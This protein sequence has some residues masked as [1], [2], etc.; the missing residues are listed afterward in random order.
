[1]GLGIRSANGLRDTL[2]S[3]LQN[4]AEEGLEMGGVLRFIFALLRYTDAAN[5]TV[6]RATLEGGRP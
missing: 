5:G 4:L 2:P 1:M 6:V 3:K